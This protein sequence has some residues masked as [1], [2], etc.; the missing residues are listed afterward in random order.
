MGSGDRGNVVPR[1]AVS[2]L[3]ERLLLAHEKGDSAALSVL[4]SEAADVAEAAG[5]RDRAAFFLTHA[6]IFALDAGIASAGSAHAKLVVW[7]RDI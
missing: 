3:E 2:R 5:E 7:G 4:Y 6:W 1:D